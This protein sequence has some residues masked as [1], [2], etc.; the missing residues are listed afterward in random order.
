MNKVTDP[1]ITVL[2]SCY[3]AKRWLQEAIDSV[4]RQT[5]EN[6]EFIIVD[7]GSTDETWSII[8]SNS[9]KDVRIVKT[10]KV[11]TGLADS[12]N[13]GIAHAK[14]TW[15]A[16]LD[17]DDLCEPTRLEE[18]INFIRKHLEVVLLGTGFL[19]L[20]GK[21][22]ILKCHS[23]PAGHNRLV[24]HLKRSMSFFPHSSA[25]YNTV[26]VG[27]SGGYNPRFRRAED[28]DLWLRLSE[29]GK[30]ACL[31]KPL[32][33][34]RKHSDQ[35]SRDQGGERQLF[36]S[37]AAKVCHF[38]RVSGTPAPSSSK[39]VADW[40]CFLEWIENNIIEE[41]AFQKRQAWVKARAAFFATENRLIGTL[42]FTRCLL[43]SGHTGALVWEKFFG[44]SM[45]KRLAKE[46]MKLLC[47]VS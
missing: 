16:R 27:N 15:I 35:I 44:S 1:E 20:D 13:A 26:M 12:L 39:E 42:N 8:Q 25:F 30:L 43:Q 4:L 47:S 10:K 7:D 17:A 3:N 34:I 41:G 9:D 22:S 31:G 6:F 29:R 28:T 38:L 2:M 5:F 46:W 33:K 21:G 18:Q 40:R 24:H 32:V 23:F 11:N 37:M 14:G 36:D 19:E 45:P